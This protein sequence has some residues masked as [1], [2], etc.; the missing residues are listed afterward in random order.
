MLN[1]GPTSRGEFDSRALSRLKAMGEW[2]FRHGRSIYDCTQ[3][4]EEFKVPQDCRLT[5]NAN[6]KRLYIHVFAWPF[7][8]LYLSGYKGKIKYAHLLNDASEI[9]MTEITPG[10]GI[11]HSE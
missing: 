11:G 3:A 9:K 8:H 7:K 6:T 4:S 10:I 1:V 5:Y 2:M